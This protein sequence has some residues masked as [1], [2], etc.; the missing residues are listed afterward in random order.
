MQPPARQP[1]GFWTGRAAEAIRTRIRA[2]LAEID[3]TQPEWWV[4]HQL[5][6]HP[7]GVERAAVVDTIGS[8]DTPAVIE[9]AI[10]GAVGKGW[11]DVDGTRLR[12]TETG[13]ERFRR[14]AAVQEGLQ[15][16]RMQGISVEDYATTI[17]V[18]QKTIANVGGDAWHW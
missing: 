15:A 9:A 5:S 11:I 13:T 8:N 18:L 3:V 4:L 2:A 6:L 17:T 1:I 14:A 12:P 16:E 10:D 7:D